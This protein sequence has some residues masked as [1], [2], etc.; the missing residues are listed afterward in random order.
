MRNFL[1]TPQSVT[2]GDVKNYSKYYTQGNFTGI[3][4]N[5]NP[6]TSDKNSFID[7]DNIYVDD[8]NRL[9]SR[10]PLITDTKNTINKTRN[11]FR[12]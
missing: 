4:E 2:T 5:D 11:A 8:E 3:K 1:K 9:V 10:L 7:C 6:I 12:V